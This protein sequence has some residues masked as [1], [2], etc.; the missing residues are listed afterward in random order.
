MFVQLY[1]LLSVYSLLR[2]PKRRGGVDR[3][4][5]TLPLP[6]LA[7]AMQSKHCKTVAL[8]AECL[9][10]FVADGSAFIDPGDIPE[11][12]SGSAKDNIVHYMAGFVARHC[13]KVVS[14]SHCI[15]QLT[16]LPS[17]AP[18]T[19]LTNVKLRGTLH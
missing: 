17:Q 6:S 16:K 7:G 14:C 8:V 12:S 10:A 9:S 5:L 13:K 11:P 19:A 1:R 4:G 3:P 18:Q 2:L 15:G